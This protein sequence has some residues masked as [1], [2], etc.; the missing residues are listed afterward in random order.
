MDT[1]SATIVAGGR[2]AQYQYNIEVNV[3]KLISTLIYLI[4]Q[5]TLMASLEKSCA[6]PPTPQVVG[7]HQIH[8]N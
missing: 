2:R 3:N 5:I 8:A 6:R 4:Y 1:V 7:D